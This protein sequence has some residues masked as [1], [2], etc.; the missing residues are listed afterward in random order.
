M[1][2]TIFVITRWLGFTLISLE[3]SDTILWISEAVGSDL[4]A[5]LCDKVIQFYGS[6]SRWF[7]W[8]SV[9]QLGWQLWS[10]VTWFGGNFAWREWRH[11]RYESILETIFKAGWLD[12]I[13]PVRQRDPIWAGQLNDTTCDVVHLDTIFSAHADSLDD[14]GA[15]WYNSFGDDLHNL[16]ADLITN[17]LMQ[18][19]F[20][21]WTV[22]WLDN[23]VQIWNG[24]LFLQ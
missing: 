4:E 22:S 10:R 8:S 24:L 11:F 5:I 20:E 1:T 19:G 14:F 23:L 2:C 17:D 21:Y 9:I 3:Q 12:L 7:L 13:R 6:A 18:T 16:S 15:E